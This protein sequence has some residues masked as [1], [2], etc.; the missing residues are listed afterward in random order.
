MPEIRDRILRQMKNAK[1]VKKVPNKVDKSLKYT[2]LDDFY[3]R[4]VGAEGDP[5]P[6]GYILFRAY[7]VEFLVRQKQ[8]RNTNLMR[9]AKIRKFLKEV[10]AMHKNRTM[11]IGISKSGRPGVY[12][13]LSQDVIIPEEF[14]LNGVSIV[15]EKG[16]YNR[17]NTQDM[18]WLTAV[19]ERFK[20]QRVLLYTESEN[21]IDEDI[22]LGQ[23][24]F[25]IHHPE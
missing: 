6:E 17:N 11:Y 12:D 23:E 14:Y 19:T 2:D 22:M 3:D 13:A 8:L 24:T 15:M 7:E 4:D 1:P 10:A 9:E 5:V 20:K 16:A 18:K 25:I 21:T